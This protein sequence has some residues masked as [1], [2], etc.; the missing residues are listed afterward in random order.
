MFYRIVKV[1][2]RRRNPTVFIDIKKNHSLSE[3]IKYLSYRNLQKI[4]SKK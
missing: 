3:R 1:K 2:N 4:C